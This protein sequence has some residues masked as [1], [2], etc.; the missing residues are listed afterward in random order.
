MLKR[1]PQFATQ[2]AL[3]KFRL[4]PVSRLLSVILMSLVPALAARDVEP[5]ELGSSSG[6]LS[7]RAC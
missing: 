5:D 3:R 6:P 4:P 1:R 2:Q 7:S